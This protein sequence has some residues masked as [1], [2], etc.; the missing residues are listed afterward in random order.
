M[1][2]D[3]ARPVYHPPALSARLVLASASPRRRDLLARARYAFETVPAQLDE[4]RGAEETAEAYVARLA[5]EKASSVAARLAADGD[6]IV[7]GADT[8]VVLDGDILGKPRNAGDARR[9]LRRLSGRSHDVLTGVAVVRGD[10]RRRAVERTRVTLAAL[11]DATIDWYVATGEPD[12]KAGAYGAQ[13]IAA[14]FVERIDGSYTN[15]VGL[16]LVLV[17]RLLREVGAPDL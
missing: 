12:D 4:R 5:L 6:R 10:A 16:P 3:Y 2:T 13:G 14:R 11:D 7:L 1:P 8:V 9:M 17:G 15:V